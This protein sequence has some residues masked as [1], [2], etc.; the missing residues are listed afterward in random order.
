MI[1]VFR[2]KKKIASSLRAE[3]PVISIQAFCMPEG[4]LKV[5]Y[6]IPQDADQESIQ[7]IL[8]AK[9]GMQCWKQSSNGA[10]H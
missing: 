5:P 9:S 2:N 4:S 3:K 10:G 1:K 8:E 6:T 7:K